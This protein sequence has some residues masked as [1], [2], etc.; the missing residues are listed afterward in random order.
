VDRKAKKRSDE[1]TPRVKIPPDLSALA[2]IHNTGEYYVGFTVYLCLACQYFFIYGNKKLESV[3]PGAPNFCP[4]CGRQRADPL[5]GE[6]H[7]G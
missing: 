6:S 1:K 3:L 2:V 4:N 7:D 5:R